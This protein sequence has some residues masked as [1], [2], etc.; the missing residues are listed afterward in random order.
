MLQGLYVLTNDRFFRHHEWADR[1]EQSILGGANIIQLREKNLPD[2]ALLPLA[3]IIQ[4]ICGYYDATFII[5]DRV[6]LAHKINADGVHI[7]RDD[8]QFS[9]ARQYLGPNFII[10]VS[11][12]RNIYR[13]LHLQYT[14]A[15]YVAFGS[16]FASQTKTKA[17][18]CPIS[19]IVKAKQLLNIPVCAIGGI[20]SV[21]IRAVSRTGADMFA[22]SHAVFN[23][24][25]PRVAANNLCQQAIMHR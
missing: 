18:R 20:D 17:N 11:C 22:T 13:A 5:N 2:Q 1:I 6:S 4:E 3:N 21:S 25:D 9:A 7:G 14:G 16:I 19:V 8:L 23:A 12:Y 10:G 24:A 15:D